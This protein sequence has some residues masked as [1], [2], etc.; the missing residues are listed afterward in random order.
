MKSLLVAALVIGLIALVAFG[1]VVV[2]W[3]TTMIVF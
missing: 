1:V 3:G 2:I